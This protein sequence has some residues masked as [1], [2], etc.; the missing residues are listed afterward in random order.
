MRGKRRAGGVVAAMLLL[1]GMPVFGGATGT[2]NATSRP[3]EGEEPVPTPE[4]RDR[5]LDRWGPRLSDRAFL[6]ALARGAPAM[7]P[8]FQALPEAAQ[9]ALARALLEE[10]PAEGASPEF[11]ARLLQGLL[12]GRAP[13]G[14]ALGGDPGIPG[15][16]AQVLAP[17]A[18]A[19]GA[20]PSVPPGPAWDPPAP[21]RPV[22]AY[23][24]PSPQELPAPAR[25]TPERLHLAIDAPRLPRE[26]AAD[27]PA[28]PLDPLLSLTYVGCGQ[29]DG[30]PVVCSPVPV[31]L[32]A[33]VPLD[34]DDETGPDIVVHL[35]PA[36][37]P[38]ALV[39][40]V[41]VPPPGAYVLG[42]GQQVVSDA[43]QA[44][45]PPGVGV[46]LRITAF[47]DEGELQHL[48][49]DGELGPGVHAEF[50]CVVHYPTLDNNIITP[51]AGDVRA[52]LAGKELKARA[53]ATYRLTTPDGGVDEQVRLGVDGVT[54]KLPGV[55]TMRFKVRDLPGLVAGHLLGVL[56]ISFENPGSD[57]TLFAEV[58]DRDAGG[59]PI[60]PTTV[61]VHLTPVPDLDAALDVM[62][63]G[64]HFLG[65]LAATESVLATVSY[66]DQQSQPDARST[67][68]EV[69][70]DQLPEE[71]EVEYADIADG[72]RLR[73]DASAEIQLVSVAWEHDEP[74]EGF[75]GTAM[76][77]ELPR[78]IEAVLHVDKERVGSVTYDASDAIPLV[79][80][81]FEHT[82]HAADV[83]ELGSM[84]IASLPASFDVTWDALAEPSL[85]TY[86][87]SAEA[88]P[89]AFDYATLPQGLAIHAAI[90]Q[91]PR[92]VQVQA[93]DDLMEFDARDGKDAA[94]ASGTLGDLDLAVSTDG[95]FFGAVPA[96]DHVK[97]LLL[98][99][100]DG[101]LLR[102]DLVHHAGLQYAK[103]DLRDAE[104]HFDV[105]NSERV[106][107]SFDIENE[108]ATEEGFVDEVPG[109]TT[110]DVA[111]TVITY[112]AYGDEIDELYMEYH[113][114][115]TGLQLTVDAFGVPAEI[116][117]D[118]DMDGRRV[119]YSASDR[120][121]RV[122]V[123]GT[124]PTETAGTF[125][126]DVDI[127][128][129]PARWSADWGT[130]EGENTA[131]RFASEDGSE[132][133]EIHL[134]VANHHGGAWPPH[135]AY[136][137]GFQHLCAR[138][139][140]DAEHL[141]LVFELH[142][143]SLLEF[144]K[145]DAPEDET[146]VR[147]HSS[148][149]DV[150]LVYMDLG[151]L[152]MD[153]R[154]E[155]LPSQL[156]FRYEDLAAG[157]EGKTHFAMDYDTGDPGTQVGKV[158]VGID[159]LDGPDTSYELPN[160]L[161]VELEFLD[162]PASFD[163]DMR[164]SEAGPDLTYQAAAS[165]LDIE[166]DI[167]T[168]GSGNPDPANPSASIQISAQDVGADFSMT[169]V[170]D[171]PSSHYVAV[172]CS[173]EEVPDPEPLKQFEF[174]SNPPTASLTLTLKV[175]PPE[176]PEFSGFAA[177]ECVS[178]EVLTFV[179]DFSWGALMWMGF[180]GAVI[181]IT[182]LG[183]QMTVVPSFVSEVLGDFAAFDFY[184]NA[185]PGSYV[186]IEIASLIEVCLGDG[187]DYC[188]SPLTPFDPGPLD[189]TDVT[190]Y[191][192]VDGEN[193]WLIPVDIHT[194]CLPSGIPPTFFSEWV[195]VG[196][197]PFKIDPHIAGVWHNEMHASG[198]GKWYFLPSPQN[199]ID[200]FVAQVILWAAGDDKALHPA[201]PTPPFG[202]PVP[203]IP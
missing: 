199:I 125:G 111:G 52:A 7:E 141:E 2:D 30:K 18:P 151:D 47:L 41:P 170:E 58:S 188:F 116:V 13:L 23:E 130:A 118:A 193:E 183:N 123:F 5:F 83:S 180:D 27:A 89:V 140:T 4:L 107:F 128:D 105:R 179:F 75:A 36:Y 156:E 182:G 72:V 33:P 37:L 168:W 104:S 50:H 40:G 109:R 70:L 135:C 149:H 79:E 152:R 171:E 146:E 133:G 197:M 95:T 113:E 163:V 126:L 190:F 28:S 25:R 194:D 97:L 31:P 167:R 143:V 195:F 16:A 173:W 46:T 177:R 42:Q 185:W 161:H 157:Q 148:L 102:L 76:V 26:P 160:S 78:S 150:F 90:S 59:Q 29:L 84:S 64:S 134:D 200:P 71:V 119:A 165:T 176:E 98:P 67:T 166:A 155:D 14:E 181:Q 202:G 103:A 153:L 77:H 120:V 142:K 35:L 178:I 38:D 172:D 19:P 117:V 73:Y 82:D 85:Y 203:C 49:C 20:R 196:T 12:F 54:S 1:A 66:D 22:A 164:M 131:F 10:H 39:D 87:G 201:V 51:V 6:E 43:T 56:N 24:P 136:K 108:D 53:W 65:R 92:Y 158:T 129:I 112:R 21:S 122:V 93:S 110:V 189:L 91:V 162:V 99:E 121:T 187:T 94:Q 48:P 61:A 169:T 55:S 175:K 144:R 100:G 192:G 138:I 86:E 63:D 34:V 106:Y 127:L 88:G 9:L 115:P 101:Q 96:G 8:E 174:H 154:V 69:V 145:R 74:S 60:N 132:V 186:D 15:D 139:D 68:T 159:S 198:G 44:L 17:S 147:L 191:G 184:W 81:A 57:V 80:V 11:A 62:L 45:V 3:D 32:G 124:I 137:A 114:K